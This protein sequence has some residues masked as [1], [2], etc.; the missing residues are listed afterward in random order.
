[1]ESNIVGSR[2]NVDLVR[3]VLIED[4]VRYVIDTRRR[5]ERK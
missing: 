3:V 2:I 5:I 1:M 4:R